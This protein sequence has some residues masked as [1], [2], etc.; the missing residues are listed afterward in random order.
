MPDFKIIYNQSDV[1]LVNCNAINAVWPRCAC[2]EETELTQGTEVWPHTPF[3]LQQI[4]MLVDPIVHP[5]VHILLHNHTPC[6]THTDTQRPQTHGRD[7]S[8]PTHS[9]VSHRQL[10]LSPSREKTFIIMTPNTHTHTH[11]RK[12]HIGR[13]RHKTTLQLV[14]REDDSITSYITHTVHVSPLN[15][16]IMNKNSRNRND[17][18]LPLLL[19]MHFS[20]FHSHCAIQT[21]E[22]QKATTSAAYSSS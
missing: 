7:T 8:P 17:E 6:H 14:M 9:G 15:K 16:N 10:L 3:Q 21:V 1:S 18:E 5:Y 13:K 2:R 19:L 12:Q 20:S 22:K 4:K 11:I